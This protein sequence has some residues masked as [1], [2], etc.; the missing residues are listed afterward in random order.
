MAERRSSSTQRVAADAALPQK[1]RARRRL[2]GALALSLLA[3]IVLPL[4]LESEPRAPTPELVLQLP[5]RDGAPP[6]PDAET[7]ASARDA[8]PNPVPPSITEPTTQSVPAAS[9]APVAPV[10]LPTAKPAPALP[11]KADPKGTKAAELK[12]DAKSAAKA[13]DTK[14]ADAKAADAKA[15]DARAV[16]AKAADAKA[17]D[18]KGADTKG[19]VYWVQVGAFRG[20]EAASRAA[21]SV[22][23]AGLPAHAEKLSMSNGSVTRVRV[24]PF[25]DRDAAQRAREQLQARGVQ[26]AIIAP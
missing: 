13:A 24:G 14:A 18:A 4:M 10:E 11:P 1:K 6:M 16:D 7:T 5:S 3:A 25:R 2:I 20:D 8:K 12:P 23:S 21:D 17:A 15:A 19:G 26:A 22:R 9:T